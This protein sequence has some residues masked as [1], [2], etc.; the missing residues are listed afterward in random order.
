MRLC[1]AFALLLA[2]AL[3]TGAAAAERSPIAMT[4]DGAISGGVEDGIQVFRGIPYAQAPTGDLRWHAPV[5]PAPWTGMR[6][7]TH[8]SANCPGA[9]PPGAMSEDCLYLNVWTAHSGKVKGKP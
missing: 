6:D 3:A 9:F 1:P 5:A 4:T 2:V 7:A 8:F